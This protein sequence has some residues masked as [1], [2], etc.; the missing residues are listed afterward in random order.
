LLTKKKTPKNYFP[1]EGEEKN[2]QGD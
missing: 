1:I 2:V